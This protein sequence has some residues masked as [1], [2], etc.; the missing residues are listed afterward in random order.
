MKAL[1]QVPHFLRLLKYSSASPLPFDNVKSS[2][3]YEERDEASYIITEY[4]GGGD[5][6][7]MMQVRPKFALTALT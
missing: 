4:V 5:L 1:A 2:Y 7:Q 3:R 6:L